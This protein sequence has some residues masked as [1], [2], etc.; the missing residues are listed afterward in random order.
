MTAQL[1][2][3]VEYVDCIPSK[4][5]NPLNEGPRYDTK[6]FE[7]EAPVLELWSM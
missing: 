1:S 4:G 3:A 2:R 5:E 7:G 6:P